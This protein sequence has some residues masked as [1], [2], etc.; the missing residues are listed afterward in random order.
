MSDI[1]VDITLDARGAACPGPLMELI[2]GVRAANVGTVIELLASEEQS[3][4]DVPAWTEKVGNEFLGF[5]KH[6][7]HWSIIVKKLK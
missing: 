7:N 3:I 1:Q 2:R 5:K 6:K 4:I